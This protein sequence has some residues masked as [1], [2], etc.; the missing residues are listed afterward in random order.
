MSNK[1]TVR[2]LSH[3][4]NPL[5][6]VYAEWIQS[7]TQDPVPDPEEL[8]CLMSH[9]YAGTSEECYAEARLSQDKILEVFEKVVTMKMP[10]GETIW[11]TFLLEHVPVAL[12]EQLVR[13]RIGHK[14]GDKLGADIIPDL[15]GTSSF[16]TQTTRIIDMGKF[17][18]EGEYLTPAWIDE[19]GDEPMKGYK[20]AFQCPVCG[21]MTIEWEA[22][23][24]TAKCGRGHQF[25]TADLKPG[26]TLR[27]FYDEQMRWIQ[28][29]YR[30]LVAAGMPLEDARNILPVAMM[31]RMTWTTNFKALM[32][33]LS[34]RS[35]WLAQ[36]GMWEPVIYGIMDELKKIH[37]AFGKLIDPP[38][39]GA[40]GNFNACAFGR[41]NE[42]ISNPQKG[43]Y[44][45]CSLWLNNDAC[46]HRLTGERL[47]QLGPETEKIVVGDRMPRYKKMMTKFEKLWMRNPRTGERIQVA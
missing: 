6:T 12:R 4:A 31:H 25:K 35:C 23:A 22:G 16:W 29:A 11:F 38:C 2:L 33:I 32:E 14:F 42:E 28:A 34:R 40:D 36:L 26:G 17:A 8:S 9:S 43:E 20:A 30:R 37:P 3:T 46:K 27:E 1:T 10:L 47:H 24:D 45:P 13:H 7:R 41:E 5:E 39:I 21:S 19:H 18:T 44:P 15:A